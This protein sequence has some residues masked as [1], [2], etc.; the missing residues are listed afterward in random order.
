M[1]SDQEVQD[2]QN[3]IKQEL[4]FPPEIWRA[5]FDDDTYGDGN[6]VGVV[7]KLDNGKRLQDNYVVCE[8]ANV[9]TIEKDDDIE[10]DVDGERTH[11]L[12]LIV[13]APEMLRTIRRAIVDLEAVTGLHKLDAECGTWIVGKGHETEKLWQKLTD[14]QDYLERMEYDATDTE[15]L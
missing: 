2:K 15:S 7:C 8:V 3:R 14:I 4:E 6:R 5:K 12:C 9:D 10:L 13:H 1:L 11:Q